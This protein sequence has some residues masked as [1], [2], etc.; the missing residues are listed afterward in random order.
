[1]AK[2]GIL[3]HDSADK[4]PPP[5]TTPPHQIISYG[6]PAPRP[7]AHQLPPQAWIILTVAALLP[8]VAALVAFWRFVSD[9]P[10][11]G[12]AL[13][14]LAAALLV[15]GGLG[16]AWGL[17]DWLTARRTR[18]AAEAQQAAVL[19]TRL[20]NAVHVETLPRSLADLLLL[21]Q[22]SIRFELARAPFTQHPVLSTMSMSNSAPPALPAPTDD[23]LGLTP[24]AE[25]M[26]WADSLPHLLIAGRTDSGKT[27]H[28]QAILADRA[29][30]GEQIVLLDPHWQP[31][32][33]LG[34]EAIGGGRAYGDILDAFMALVHE[35]DTRYQAYEQG[36]PT[37]AF[38]RLSV[39]VDEVPSIVDRATSARD[40]RWRSFARTLG[41]EARKVRISVILLTQSPLVQDI[42]LNTSM[43]ANFARLALGDQARVLLQEE[44]NAKRKQALLDLLRDRPKP[45][46]MEY[47]SAWYALRNDD[48]PRLAAR[49]VGH[50][51][52]VWRPS[53][54]HTLH[55]EPD[56]EAAANQT[57]N[58]AQQDATDYREALIVGLRRE[59]KT[60]EEIRAELRTLGLGFDNRE[61]SAI[62][63]R[64]GLN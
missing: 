10:W 14:F 18:L 42:Q 22:E 53:G 19:R 33:W 49:D 32:K 20:G 28:A 39:L 59:G 17:L 55:T 54:L 38:P 31:G 47:R 12:E 34:L 7:R 64:H 57:A 15:L 25:W 4:V 43:R 26:P 23:A 36:T 63:T 41:S 50:L 46:A 9:R 58:R 35:L 2:D 52:S 11:L 60:R 29:E 62:L 24:E 56:G 16:A 3:I 13:G 30:A 37:E 44:P 48:V 5:A 51:A 8:V 1:M 40:P 27:T 21:E 6:P 61:F 45:A